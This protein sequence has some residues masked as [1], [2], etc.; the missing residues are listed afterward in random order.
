LNPRNGLCLSNLHDAAFDEGLITLDEKLSVI[1]S[2]RLKAY[3]PQNVLEQNFVPF[4]GTPIRL[5]EKIAE[6]DPEFLR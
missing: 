5:P 4:E 2:K 1:L 3:F 6:P